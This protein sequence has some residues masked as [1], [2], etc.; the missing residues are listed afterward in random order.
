MSGKPERLTVLPLADQAV[1]PWRNGGGSTREVARAP[2]EGA[3]FAWRVSV[4]RIEAD[5]PFSLFP[6]IDRTLWLLAG[7]GM[8][9][10]IDGTTVS[11]RSRFASCAFPGEAVVHARLVGGPTEDL[12]V[13][14]QRAGTRALTEIVS[15]ATDELRVC[16][17]EGA[18]SDL[19]VALT[20]E[21]SAQS[22]AGTR[23]V[24]RAG[25]ALRLDDAS[26][27]RRWILR[28]V[29]RGAALVLTFA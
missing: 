24:L 17:T 19:I 5:G 11:L 27:L 28:G 15:L 13:M 1:M 8:D 12:N 4:A 14:V 16:T 10:V 18:G 22:P 6:G 23:V 25:D 9:L 7:A 29:S 3:D 26:G 2:A 20:G 21:L